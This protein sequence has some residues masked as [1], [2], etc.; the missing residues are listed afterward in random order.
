MRKPTTLIFSGLILMAQTILNQTYADQTRHSPSSKDENNLATLQRQPKETPTS[1]FSAFTGKVTKNKVRLRLQPNLESPILK[2]LMLGDMVIVLGETEDFYAIQPPAGSKSYVFRTYILDNIVEASR[3]NVR[4]EPD[5]DAPIIAQLYSGDPIQGTVSPLN[6]KWLEIAPPSSTRFFIAKDYVEKIGDPSLMGAIEKRRDEVNMLLNSTYLASQSEMQKAFP[7][8][9]LDT[10]YAN[11]NKILQEYKTFPEQASRAK[12]LL[13]SIQ[14][15]YLQKK[16]AYL[17]AKTKIVQDDWQLKNSQLNEQVKSQQ[18]KM[19]TLEQQLRKTKGSA[20]F[21]AE[22]SSA[23]SVRLSN[24]MASWLPTEQSLY[25]AWSQSNDSHSQ[26]EYYQEQSHSAIALKGILEPYNRI[27][28]NKPGDYI[29]VNQSN[30]LPIAY[31]YSTL[32]NLQDKVGQ[33]ITIYGVA[34]DNH[35]FAFPA[36]FVLSAD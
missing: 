1:P 26:D 3:V 27:I 9:N 21:I 29:L 32:V 8:I 36:Y 14:D 7:E 34:R 24:K 13:N 11:F 19:S 10:V 2:E 28:K 18:Q 12:E 23:G 5:V 22:D 30:H 6:S 16:I 20:P 17:E 15:S 33:Q 25:E 31:L 4:L 35:N